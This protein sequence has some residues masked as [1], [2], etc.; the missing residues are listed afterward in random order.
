M[1]KVVSIGGGTGQSSLID[2][3]KEY[4]F[5]LTAVVTTMDSGGSSGRIREEFGTMAHGDLRNCLMALSSTKSIYRDLFKYRFEKGKGLKGHSFGNLF[6]LI[7]REVTGSER[8]AIERAEE[9]LEVEGR[10]LP[11]T[12][13]PAHIYARL[14]NGQ[15]IKG[16]TNIDI[17]A[18]DGKL[19]IVDCYLMPKVKTT[20]EVTKA[21]SQADIITFGPGDFY[22][23]LIPNLCV[24][25]VPEAIKKSKAIKVFIANP[26][27][28][29][30]ETNKFNLVD[31]VEVLEKYL[32]KGVLDYI[33]YQNKPISSKILNKYQPKKSEIVGYDGKIIKALKHKNIK[34]IG[35]DLIDKN[36]KKIKYNSK[37]L[38]KII[39]ELGV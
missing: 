37:K 4:P 23:S 2:G 8:E 9:I 22:T 19:K 1:R 18:H 28:K 39:Y 30:G 38:A 11:V 24:K 10:V 3:L 26:L 16:E 29:W 15:L 17:P 5:G 32:G 31:F 12:L 33:I 20:T 36:A 14:E 34:T 35:K 25:G 27:T 13:T 6:M 7:L 21:V